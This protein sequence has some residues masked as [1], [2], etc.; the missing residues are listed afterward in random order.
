MSR[1]YISPSMQEHNVGV[2]NYG[3]E[4]REMNLIAD[5]VIPILVKHGQ[6]VYRNRPA[7]SLTQ[8][9]NDSNSKKVDVHFAIHSDAGGARGAEVIAYSTTSKGYALS[10]SV[11][12]FLSALTPVADRGVKV[13]SSLFELRKTVAPSALAE[14]SFHDNIDDVKWIMEHRE[15]IAIAIAKG[16]LGYLGVKYVEPVKPAAPNVPGRIYRVQLGAF[17]DK[18]NAD[19][20]I[21]KL[22]ADGYNAII[23]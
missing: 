13:N 7:M 1:I 20:M 22:K 8:M 6:T 15:D 19:R 21:T 17:K 4:E 18:N 14:I 12:N 10:K 3:T 5:L 9:V 16:I 2:G 23:I 11:Y